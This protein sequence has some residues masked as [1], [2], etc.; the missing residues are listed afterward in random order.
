MSRTARSLI[1]IMVL[2]L[3][4]AVAVGA[5]YS[6]GVFD[7]LI[8]DGNPGTD[9]PGG[10]TDEPGTDTPG[11]DEPGTDTPGTDEPAPGEDDPDNVI[12]IGS[13]EYVRTD[14]VY[15][16]KPYSRYVFDVMNITMDGED[17]EGELTL[18]P[19]PNLPYYNYLFGEIQ[20]G[21]YQEVVTSGEVSN[22]QWRDIE[23]I[24]LD[25]WTDKGSYGS[26]M[27]EGVAVVDGK[28]VIQ[29][30]QAL[31]DLYVDQI[32]EQWGAFTYTKHYY[33]TNTQCY[34]RIQVRDENYSRG[35]FDILVTN[36][37]QEPIAEEE[38]EEPVDPDDPVVSLSVELD[39]PIV[40]D[41]YQLEQ[42]TEYNVILTGTTQSGK[43]VD[44]DIVNNFSSGSGK[45]RVGT[46]IYTRENGAITNES[47]SDIVELDFWRI[48][49]R[50]E[51]GYLA[52]GN[53]LIVTTGAAHTSYVES[54]K[55]E[56][57]GYYC[58]TNEY[59]GEV[60][61]TLQTPYIRVTLNDSAYNSVSFKYIVKDPNFS[62]GHEPEKPLEPIDKIIGVEFDTEYVITEDIIKQLYPNYPNNGGA[63]L[64]E[65][66]AITLVNFMDS[67]VLQVEG[68]TVWENG[69]WK[70]S[71][72][73][74]DDV[75][76][77]YSIGNYWDILSKFMTFIHDD[78][79]TDPGEPGTEE[80]E[81]PDPEE[82]EPD[83]PVVQVTGIKFN[84]SYNITDDIIKQLYPDYPNSGAGTLLNNP[85]IVIV[86]VMDSVAI[87]V[88]NTTVW[89]NGTW[90]ENSYYF[91]GVVTIEST[92]EY[93]GILSQFMTLILVE[94]SEPES[95]A[96]TPELPMTAKSIVFNKYYIFTE[97]VMQEIMTDSIDLENGTS[98]KIIADNLFMAKNGDGNYALYA[99]I[100]ASDS[101]L[102]WCSANASYTN[103]LTNKT[104]TYSAGWHKTE[105]S[106][107]LGI[108]V[109][110]LGVDWNILKEFITFMPYDGTSDF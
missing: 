95:P 85:A 60:G 57:W 106:P 26:K 77:I 63:G 44:V 68:I 30:G 2:L 93:W 55:T 75:V 48:A 99:G 74:F 12:I 87:Q 66:P 41:I 84:T 10:G 102:V 7:S 71:G 39:A 54:V 76:G 78:E 28:I 61:D 43:T 89:E 22:T 72:Y 20:V 91:D 49:N 11:T 46:H 38:P 59:Y 70:E 29:T 90:K 23:T 81:K 83:E 27:L 82:P 104:E 47:W 67:V 64:L 110:A 50:S 69:I 79:T 21:T 40:D 5:C 53:T 1:V 94:T 18:N 109:E 73:Y 36:E 45:I 3:I 6:Q 62:G 24:N 17:I 86:K 14:G 103:P 16:I 52:V 88:E 31:E 58:G 33:K 15:L 97:E 92:G 108:R 107:L 98:A 32:T 8:P 13:Q 37:G 51:G 100:K 4:A 96:E 25:E 56:N 105:Y 65:K 42:Y 19:D 80:P 101:E 35:Y 34:I 9:T